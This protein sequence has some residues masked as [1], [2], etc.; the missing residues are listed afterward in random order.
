MTETPSVHTTPPRQRHQD[1]KQSCDDRRRSTGSPQRANH[2]PPPILRR[3]TRHV[4]NPRVTTFAHNTGVHESTHESET[5]PHGPLHC[6]IQESKSFFLDQI[7]DYRGNRKDINNLDDF[8]NQDVY[9]K[10][11]Y[12]LEGL[13]TKQL[14]RLYHHIQQSRTYRIDRDD[15]WEIDHIVSHCTKGSSRKKVKLWLEIQWKNTEISWVRGDSVRMHDPQS[16]I[17]YAKEHALHKHPDFA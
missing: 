6:P 10:P 17:R 8:D 3:S 5:L 1:Q 2:R 7:L 12:C 16:I 13:S 11:S 15:T 4:K 9:D 14:D